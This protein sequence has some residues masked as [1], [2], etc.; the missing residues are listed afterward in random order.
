M[1]EVDVDVDVIFDAVAKR[2]TF[3]YHTTSEPTA[4][5]LGGQL[6]YGKS[7]LALLAGKEHE[8]KPFLKVNGD[9]YRI[10]HPQHDMLLKD[11][12]TYSEETQ[13]FSSVFTEK[14]IEEAIRNRFNIIVERTGSK[15]EVPLRTA[16]FF[17]K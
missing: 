17:R 3:G 4:I 9:N 10:Y 12:A 6:V 8:G 7:H 2:L 5:L 15:P 14:L 13:I 16:I 11:A 1:P